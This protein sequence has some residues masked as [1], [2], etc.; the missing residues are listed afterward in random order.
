MIRTPDA[1][2]TAGKIL[3][4]EDHAEELAAYCENAYQEVTDAVAQVPESERI[5]VYYA[6]GPDGLKTEPQ[7]SPHFT[8]FAVAG[9]VDAAQCEMNGGGGMTQVSLENVITW[10]PQVII[11]WDDTYQSGADD[12]IR[13]SSDWESIDA[14]QNGRVY[15]LPCL[16]YAWGDRPPSVT[17]YIGM[18][19][20]ANKLYPE[21]YDVDMVA[22]TQEFYKLFYQVDLTEEQAKE[23]LFES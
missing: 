21:Y 14:V 2:R 9:A 19:W 4:N 15:T 18:Q 23:V 16:P 13:T 3:G 7:Q 6:E 8:T 10:N 20:L 12:L 5:T 1:Y 17:R 22:K 11:A